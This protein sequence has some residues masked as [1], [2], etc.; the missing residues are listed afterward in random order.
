MKS[1]TE[2]LDDFSTQLKLLDQKRGKNRVLLKEIISNMVERH[3][4][5]LKNQILTLQN[6]LLRCDRTVVEKQQCELDRLRQENEDHVVWRE[7]Y[8]KHIASLRTEMNALKHP[9][10]ALEGV[11][12]SVS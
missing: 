7:R 4:V 1:T 11:P 8:R 9:S 2:F 12:S 5:L 6:E 10:S 3:C